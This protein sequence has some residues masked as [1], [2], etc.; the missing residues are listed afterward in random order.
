MYSSDWN[1]SSFGYRGR[2]DN[3]RLEMSEWLIGT[4]DLSSKNIKLEG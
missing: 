2:Q 4:G 3:P 1:E